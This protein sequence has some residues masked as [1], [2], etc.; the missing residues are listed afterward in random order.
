MA[1]NIGFSGLIQHLRNGLHC[2]SL[3]QTRSRLALDMN[4]NH[5]LHPELDCQ[6]THP[7]MT[8]QI[9]IGL[10]KM[11]Q[12]VGWGTKYQQ[13][14]FHWTQPTGDGLNAKDINEFDKNIPSVVL[15]N[16]LNAHAEQYFDDTMDNT[17]ISKFISL[18]FHVKP[19]PPP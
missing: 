16:E 19:P 4:T 9:N 12:A 5:Y 8:N 1:E 15:E 10:N 17:S 13:D 18:L 7:E 11:P 6:I 2:H 14:W 3:R